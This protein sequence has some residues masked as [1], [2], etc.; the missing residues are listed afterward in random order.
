MLPRND[1]EEWTHFSVEWLLQSTKDRSRT[2]WS[3]LVGRASDLR[4]CCE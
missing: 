1:I 2:A 4:T 3:C